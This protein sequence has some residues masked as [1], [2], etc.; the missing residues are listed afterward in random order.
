MTWFLDKEYL[1]KLDLR[2]Y[3]PAQ[4]ARRT[5]VSLEVATAFVDPA[6]KYW[7]STS[8][9]HGWLTG[10]NGDGKPTLLFVGTPRLASQAEHPLNAVTTDHQSGAITT[11]AIPFELEDSSWDD[12]LDVVEEAIGFQPMSNAP[13]LAFVHPHIWHFAVVPFSWHHEEIL[14]GEGEPS[15]DDVAM[16][17]DWIERGNYVLHHGNAYYMSAEGEVESS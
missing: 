11:Q 3:D 15:E 5:G 2:G 13:M 1:A 14:R 12:I 8:P 6:R 4:I 9:D 16:L 17:R 7:V 10:A